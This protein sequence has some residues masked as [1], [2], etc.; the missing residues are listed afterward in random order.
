M[1]NAR[2]TPRQL[3]DYVTHI[4]AA[5]HYA[6]A[7]SGGGDSIGAMALL[8][9]C[10]KL[11][12]A[13]AFTVLTVNHGLRKEAVEETSHVAKMAAKL[14]LSCKILSIKSK[15]P[16]TGI[17]NWARES[18]YQLM[19]RWCET[20]QV[21]G[22]ILA[23]HLHDQMETFLMRLARGSGIDG[24]SAMAAKQQWGKI[25]LIRPFLE[26]HPDMLRAVARK[27]G[28][29]WIEDPTNQDEIF[30]RVR[31]R[32]I[33]PLL[34]EKTGISAAHMGRSIAQLGEVRHGLDQWA[35]HILR[36]LWRDWGILQIPHA[37]FSELP[38]ALKK[39][40]IKRG[41]SYFSSALYP[42]SDKKL[43]NMV[44]R[45]ETGDI[46]SA[47]LS[48]CLICGR[49][50]SVFIGRETRY[51]A[52]LPPLKLV[53]GDEILWDNRFY[54]TA[55]IN[56]LQVKSMD[57][58]SFHAFMAKLPSEKVVN[59]EKRLKVMPKPYLMILPCLWKGGKF[60]DSP[61]L[62]ENYNIFRIKKPL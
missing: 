26:D 62:S 59:L 36:P 9:K 49:R 11:K 14:G 24:L 41:L 47:T 16:K 20:H 18:R 52:A 4:H 2:K 29:R 54:L 35:D 30:E 17:Q 3:L 12:N 40:L 8:A 22:L 6:I 31:I 38:L 25:L 19:Q 42:P 44:T 15:P 13:P 10:A 23:H 28:V 56:G 46:F 58:E 37:L 34:E 5:A 32:K 1:R 57:K 7:V 61:V 60:Y 39:R 21:E 45:I 48:E 43:Q 27:S 55:P 51:A 50:G 33:L 53:K